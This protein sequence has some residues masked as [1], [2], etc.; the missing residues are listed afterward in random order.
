MPDIIQDLLSLQYSQN[1]EIQGMQEANVDLE[2][3]PASVSLATVYGVVTDGTAPI[4]DATVKLFD[5]AGQPYQHTM[6]AAD[7]TYTLSGI[8]A[9]TYSLGAVKEGYLLSDAAGVTLSAGATTQMNLTCTA[10]TSL[11]LGTI[12]GVLTV[13][14]PVQGTS[15]PPGRRQDHP[16]GRPWHHTGHHLHRIRRR[17]RLL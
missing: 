4:P 3:P 9:G 8:P 12:A 7:G 11:S 1:F 15:T 10:E 16:A 2:L 17:V 14:D 13:S 5:S 6:T